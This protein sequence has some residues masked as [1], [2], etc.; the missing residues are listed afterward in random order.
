MTG[1]FSLGKLPPHRLHHF[2]QQ[3][4]SVDDVAAVRSVT[5]M[6]SGV[7]DSLGSIV[8]SASAGI[9]TLTEC[10]QYGQDSSNA[11]YVSFNSAGGVCAWFA[12]CQCLASSSTCL[13][14]DQWTSIAVADAFL[15][16]KGPDG[17]IQLVSQSVSPESALVT[18]AAPG[19]I[20]AV[21]SGSSYEYECDDSSSDLM[22]SF[23]SKCQMDETMSFSR[24][25]AGGAL[26]VVMGVIA[27]I[28]GVA[29][30]FDIQDNSS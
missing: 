15:P 25:V 30:A 20:E 9:T 16:A 28:F 24:L 17:T 18:T 1:C 21:A 4:S 7:Q 27:V 14:G 23:Q 13:G 22:Q 19:S 6:C 10:A 2:V 3:Q 8:S 29:Y 11:V 12:D 5:G 26:L